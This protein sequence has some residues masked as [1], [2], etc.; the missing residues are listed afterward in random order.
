MKKKTAGK[1]LWLGMLVLALVFGMAVVGC[2][3]GK[4]DS[5]DE[6]TYN[7]TGTWNLTIQGQAYTLTI[8]GNSWSIL[9]IGSGT[10]TRNGN[11]GA[12]SSNGSNIGTATMTSSTTMTLNLNSYSG[13]QGTYSAT[14][15]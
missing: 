6:T 11:V 8:T 14:K 13:Y 10:F 5:G 2:E 7:P 12:L 1:G 9:G 4:G 15:Q 3:D